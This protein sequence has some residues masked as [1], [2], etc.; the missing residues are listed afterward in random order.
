MSLT[1]WS[2]VCNLSETS[3]KT[4]GLTAKPGGRSYSGIETSGS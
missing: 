1:T 3:G 2:D 4:L